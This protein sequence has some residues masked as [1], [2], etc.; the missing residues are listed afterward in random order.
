MQLKVNLLGG[1]SA[2]AAPLAIDAARLLDRAARARGV[3]PQQQLSLFFKH[4]IVD[5]VP[6]HD[7]FRQRSLLERWVE[8]T[9]RGRT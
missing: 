6:E 5:A 8:T 3:G 1:D 7:L 2:L 9:E 4:P